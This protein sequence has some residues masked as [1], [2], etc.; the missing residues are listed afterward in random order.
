[1]AAFLV[2]L[3][4]GVAPAAASAG[5]P[6][7]SH[8]RAT[9][10]VPLLV[11]ADQPVGVVNR[12]LVGF[13]H[14]TGGQPAS[15]V[16][17]LR[18]HFVRIDASLESVSPARG[19]LNLAPLLAHVADVRG[20]GGE[21]LVILSYT[22]AWL[23]QPF[24]PLGD[25]T[26]TPPTDLGAWRQLVHD[27]VHALATAPQ[28]ATWFEAWNEPDLPTFWAGLPTQWVDTA[29]ASAQAVAQVQAETGRRLRFGG[30]ATAAP[31][32]VYLSAFL[33]RFRDRSLPLDFVSWHYYGNYPCLG[34][35]GAESGLSGGGLQAVAGCH[36]PL[37]SP[38]A[39]GPQ[40]GLMRSLTTDALAGSGRPLPELILDEWNLSAGGLDRRHDT[41]EGAAFDAA[42]LA[43]MQASDLD[44][45]AFF[46]ATDTDRRPGNFGLVTLDGHRKLAW[47]AFW[48]WQRL[49]RQQ[50]RVEGASP[51][52]DL[53]AVASRSP[54]GHRLTVL[55]ASFSASAPTDRTVDLGVAGLPAGHQPLTVTVRRIDAAHSAASE[56]A[57][58]AVDGDHLS[59]A[60]PAQS[61]A[62]LEV[63]T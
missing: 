48:L 30:P 16:A 9:S 55:L 5:S 59:I 26:K 54:G 49:A 28:P 41:N 46:A 21:P 52:A 23:G 43:E 27:V 19:V 24:A 60:L 15:A 33:A 63:R 57:P 17:P 8:A 35:D 1:M 50:L 6:A 32:P 7:R 47:W 45:S 13:D 39:Y 56:T 10:T 11:H 44:A 38:A 36:N 14:H 53:W 3:T 29:A 34:P 4:P 61:I 62:F 12:D 40:V 2:F 37:A 25:R 42:T 51:L 20:A 18:P 31:D 58:V 22:P